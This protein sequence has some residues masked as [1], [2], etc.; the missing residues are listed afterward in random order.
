MGLIAPLRLT[1]SV[2]WEAPMSEHLS[3]RLFLRRTAAVAPLAVAGASTTILP[4]LAG[5]SEDA[6]LF[7]LG[8]QFQAALSALL[9]AAAHKEAC[10]S[11]YLQLMPPVPPEASPVGPQDLHMT[12]E[13]TDA[14]GCPVVGPNGRRQRVYGAGA[15]SRKLV[16]IDGRTREAKRYQHVLTVLATFHSEDDA[17][18]AASGIEQASHGLG[19]AQRDL[20]DIVN[21]IRDAKAHT[22]DGLAV[23]ASAIAALQGAG[24]ELFYSMNRSIH[25]LVDAVLAVAEKPRPETARYPFDYV[26]AIAELESHGIDL[27]GA[28]DGD[29]TCRGVSYRLN[30]QSADRLSIAFSCRRGFNPF[31]CG[32]VLASQGKTALPVKAGDPCGVWA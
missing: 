25:S 20:T 11:A 23:K 12:Y 2:S 8:E 18:Q 13:R 14:D 27:A 6:E 28:M 31:E 17:A 19:G 24:D 9:V 16:D 10:R 5:P 3:R 26:S 1:A 15:V 21:K 22:I 29:G 30:G 4:A 7:A 32:R